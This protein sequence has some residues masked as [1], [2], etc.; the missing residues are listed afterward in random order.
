MYIYDPPNLK[1]ICICALDFTVYRNEHDNYIDSVGKKSHEKNLTQMIIEQ[2]N[3]NSCNNKNM[4]N[5]KK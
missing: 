1:Q 2:R 5:D 3:S 4:I